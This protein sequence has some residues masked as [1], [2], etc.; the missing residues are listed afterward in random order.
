GERVSRRRQ[1]T[2][3]TINPDIL[4]RNLAELHPGQPVVH[5]EHGV[6]SGPEF[7]ANSF[8]TAS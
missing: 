2:R 7:A 3:R 1:D 4:I 8:I 6:T 5:L